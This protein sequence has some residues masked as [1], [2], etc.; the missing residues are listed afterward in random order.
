MLLAVA[1]RCR[2]HLL[3]PLALQRLARLQRPL[4][5][6]LPRVHLRLLQPRRQPLLQ[7]QLVR[8]LRQLRSVR[9][10]LHLQPAQRLPRLLQ[11]RRLRHCQHSPPLR[12]QRVLRL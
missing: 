11:R 9:L 5:R 10:R 12:L 7:V 8:R 2:V 4:V 1:V 3:L 6:C